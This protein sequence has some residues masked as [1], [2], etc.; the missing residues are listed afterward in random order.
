[1][2][3]EAVREKVRSFDIAGEGLLSSPDSMGKAEFRAKALKVAKSTINVER[4]SGKTAKSTVLARSFMGGA[5]NPL[6]TRGGSII[7][8]LQKSAFQFQI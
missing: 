5:P 1:M 7:V 8:G 4:D 2:L 3:E 6:L